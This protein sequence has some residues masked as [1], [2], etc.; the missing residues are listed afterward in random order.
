MVLTGLLY[1]DQLSESGLLLY[2]KDSFDRHDDKINERLPEECRLYLGT[3]PRSANIPEVLNILGRVYDQD[4]SYIKAF[5]YY[6]DA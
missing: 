2:L 3:F 4:G 5:V 1:A 6:L